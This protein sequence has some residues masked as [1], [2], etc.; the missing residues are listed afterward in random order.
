M[1][2]VCCHTP[3]PAMPPERE[4]YFKRLADIIRNNYFGPRCGVCRRTT[5]SI[6]RVLRS[7]AEN[8]KI[9]Q[10]V[11]LCA[12]AR[13]QSHTCSLMMTTMKFV[14]RGD[15]SSILQF[16]IGSVAWRRFQSFSISPKRTQSLAT[17]ND[18]TVASDW[19]CVC[20]II[21]RRIF[22]FHMKT[23]DPK[24]D[25]SVMLWSKSFPIIFDR[26]I[27]TSAQTPTMD[28]ISSTKS[29]E[30]LVRCTRRSMRN[31]LD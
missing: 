26:R 24:F 8:D 22:H 15:Q 29:V 31:Q 1:A 30:F 17:S 19:V 23:N 4:Y 27:V 14:H 20:D 7:K 10:C 3:L 21:F 16:V 5:R 6:L 9:H 25:S 11:A 13:T 28:G 2:N 12:G 18:A